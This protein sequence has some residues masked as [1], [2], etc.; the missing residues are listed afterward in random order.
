MTQDSIAPSPSFRHRA[1]YWLV[2]GVR[3]IV[4]VMPDAMSRGLGTLLG[5][6]F[7]LVDRRHRRVAM[8]QLQ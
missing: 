4:G 6:L 1:E 8:D 7:F 2:A 5:L 3:W